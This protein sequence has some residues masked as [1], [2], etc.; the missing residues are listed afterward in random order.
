MVASTSQPA[1]TVEHWFFLC[2]AIALLGMAILAVTG[3]IKPRFAFVSSIVAMAV[4]AT[5]L[6]VR[7]WVTSRVTAGARPSYP[8]NFPR[9]V[10]R[11]NGGSRLIIVSIAILGVAAVMFGTEGGK[12]SLGER[13]RAVASWSAAAVGIIV[14]SATLLAAQQGPMVDRMVSSL[15][16]TATESTLLMVADQAWSQCASDCTPSAF[17]TMERDDHFPEVLYVG[18]DDLSR[19]DPGTISVSIGADGASTEQTRVGLAAMSDSGVCVLLVI[20]DASAHKHLF[21]ETADPER[22]SGSDALVSIQ[23]PSPEIGGWV[24]IEKAFKTWPTGNWA[25][26][27]GPTVWSGV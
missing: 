9:L 24:A 13:W 16:T 6:G 15:Q 23:S 19:T 1:T 4:A 26:G 21:G 5:G 18:G 3:F 27:G 7:L 22:C 17:P 14:A 10:G 20:P 25:V 12:R 2:L 11:L 8:V